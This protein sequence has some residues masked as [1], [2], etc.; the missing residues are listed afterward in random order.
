MKAQVPKCRSMAPQ[1]SSGRPVDPNLYLASDAIPYAAI[2]LV[3][4]LE[5]RSMS[6]I[7]HISDMKKALAT[8]LQQMLKKANTC[9]LT[10]QQK[11]RLYKAS[12]CSRLSWLLTIESPHL[13]V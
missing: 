8:H 11:L 2:E 3:K 6:P 1:G 7:I 12:I 5:S 10:R 4:F 9:P 13:M